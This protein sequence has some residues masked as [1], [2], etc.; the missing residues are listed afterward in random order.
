MYFP[1][2]HLLELVGKSIKSVEWIERITD[3]VQA[4]SRK[5]RSGLPFS[6]LQKLSKSSGQ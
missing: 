2:G 4:L 3:M 6:A 5:F 1:I